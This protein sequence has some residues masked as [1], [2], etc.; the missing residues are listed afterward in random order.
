M[1]LELSRV[2]KQRTQV[3]KAPVR[4]Q[5]LLT[6]KLNTVVVPSRATKGLLVVASTLSS[7]SKVRRTVRQEPLFPRFSV[8]TEYSE[9]VT[10]CK[11]SSHSTSVVEHYR[12][13]LPLGRKRET[14]LSRSA[15]QK[16]DSEEVARWQRS[17]TVKKLV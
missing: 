15:K 5:R 4:G 13:N 3:K 17:K 1:K 2:F 14:T 8:R 6:S 12:K 11:S 10:T 16:Q 7:C 9:K